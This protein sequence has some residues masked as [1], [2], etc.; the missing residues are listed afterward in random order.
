MRKTFFIVVLAILNLVSWQRCVEHTFL[1]PV[2]CD[3]NPLVLELVSVE[4]SDCALKNGKVEVLASG[5]TGNYRFRLG[6]SEEQLASVFQDLA[7]GVYEISASD[8]SDCSTSLEAVVKN[9]NGVSITFETTDAGC[10]SANGSITVTPSNGTVPYNFK[11]NNS[12]FTTDNTF[13]DLARGD[14][15]IVVND[16]T[17]CEINQT[18]KIRSGISFATSISP[19]IQTNCIVSGCHNGSQFPDFR[20]FKN[21]HDNASQIKT[22]TGNRTMPEDGSL[23]QAEINSIACWVDDGALEN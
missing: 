8:E 4:D 22:L 15:T 11:I 18:V 6:D 20:V 16:S 7:A 10:N 12:G 17:G 13:T 14:Y 23:T 9:K 1:G 2:N 19:I 3:Q 21:I 5:G